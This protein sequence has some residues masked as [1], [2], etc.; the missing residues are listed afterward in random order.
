MRL[1]LFNMLKRYN[2]TAR[3]STFDGAPAYEFSFRQPTDYTN[4]TIDLDIVIN[5]NWN[6]CYIDD[7]GAYYWINNITILNSTQSRLHLRKDLLATFRESIRSTEGVI[8]Y[9]STGY[10]T[11]LPD[12]RI[13]IEGKSTASITRP[14]KD[15]FSGNGYYVLN[16]M[17]L[18][19]N[20]GF[21]GTYFMTE[22]ILQRVIEYFLTLSD[23]YVTNT[24]KYYGGMAQCLQ[25]CKYIPLELPQESTLSNIVIANIDTEIK[26]L[27]YNQKSALKSLDCFFAKPAPYADFRAVTA[28]EYQLYLP[29]IGVVTLA[30]DLVAGLK[31][32][33]SVTAIVDT[34][35][36]DLTYHIADGNENID[37]AEI[38]VYRANCSVN[39][40]T[41][42]NTTKPSLEREIAQMIAGGIKSI[43]SSIPE[44]TPF[45]L[46]GIKD[47]LSTNIDKTYN[48]YETMN[49]PVTWQSMGSN[50]GNAEFTAAWPQYSR[51]ALIVRKHDTT[52]PSAFTATQGRPVRKSGKIENYPGYVKMNGA[53]FESQGATLAEQNEITTFLNGGFYNE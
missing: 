10:N 51:P 2:S 19:P 37:D 29:Y 9:S 15:F 52:D 33:I 46:L 3:P 17:S 40:S 23:D 8:L 21:T 18:K 27:A 28:C 31:Y 4:P 25:Y 14:S 41:A 48:L 20:D 16:V 38:A 35:T 7:M 22:G 45:A 44:Y 1:Y 49:M 43:V 53:F 42:V 12:S 39:V 30:P 6:Y 47:T 5:K 36:G 26:A 11:M 50:G 32:G 24:T 13:L 34:C